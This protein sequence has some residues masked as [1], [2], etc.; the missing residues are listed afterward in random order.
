MVKG[1]PQRYTFV[2]RTNLE[3]LIKEVEGMDLS[4]KIK[5]PVAAVAGKAKVDILIV[6]KMLTTAG[7]VN[8]SYQAVDMGG[9]IVATTGKELI[10]LDTGAIETGKSSL[11]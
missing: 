3:T 5:N 9:N 11:K 6:G 4:G 8:L 10:R 1:A 2:T 7:G